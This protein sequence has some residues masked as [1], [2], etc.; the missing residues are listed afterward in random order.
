MMPV[1]LQPAPSS[2][3]IVNPMLVRQS[4]AKEGSPQKENKA[5]N[6]AAHE[7]KIGPNTKRQR[8]EKEGMGYGN[9]NKG[10]GLWP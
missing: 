1:R 3:L 6:R 10:L 7:G 4:K 8:V 5:L 2:R 9:R